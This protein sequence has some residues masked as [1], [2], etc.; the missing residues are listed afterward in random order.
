MP[1]PSSAP[2]TAP[3]PHTDSHTHA[4]GTDADAVPDTDAFKARSPAAFT[5]RLRARSVHRPRTGG[6]GAGARTGRAASPSAPGAAIGSASR[7]EALALLTGAFALTVPQPPGGSA[8]A[9]ARAA[10]AGRQ[11]VDGHAHAVDRRPRRAGGCRA[12]TAFE[13]W[14]VGGVRS[15]R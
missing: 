15:I 6:T 3:Q 12:A 10:T 7:A 11:H 5:L 1:T 13:H 9:D 4:A 2:D 8:P 14:A